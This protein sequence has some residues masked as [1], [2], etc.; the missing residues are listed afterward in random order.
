MSSF[1]RQ[2]YY[3]QKQNRNLFHDSLYYWNHEDWSI[4]FLAHKNKLTKKSHF[5]CP[6]C[7]RNSALKH[8]LKFRAESCKFLDSFIP[9]K[10]K[11]IK[12]FVLI[13]YIQFQLYYMLMLE[14]KLVPQFLRTGLKAW[15]R[16]MK[17]P[18]ITWKIQQRN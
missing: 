11:R 5:R 1:V 6:I 12:F 4:L 8:A 13:N 7:P 18:I 14:M 17:N 3:Y 9:K 15:F 2:F 16:F 10:I